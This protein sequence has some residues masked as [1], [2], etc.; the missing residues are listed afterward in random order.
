MEDIA[1]YKARGV[2][3]VGGDFNMHIGKSPNVMSNVDCESD[4][5]AEPAVEYER[6]SEHDTKNDTRG[7]D[8]LE[9]MNAAGMVVLNGM[10]KQGGEYTYT[11]NKGS[12]VVDYVFILESEIEGGKKPRIYIGKDRIFSDHCMASGTSKRGR[13]D[14][15]AGKENKSKEGGTEERGQRTE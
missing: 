9:K 12:T 7:N 1:V 15:E 13:W 6:T 11:S 4:Y 2:V 3:I 10:F 14:E 5:F 8:I